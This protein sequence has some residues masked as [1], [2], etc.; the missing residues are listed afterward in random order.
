MFWRNKPGKNRIDEKSKQ[1]LNN[2]SQQDSREQEQAPAQAEETED[3]YQQESPSITREELLMQNEDAR[4]MFESIKS[5]RQ[6]VEAIKS[7]DSIAFSEEVELKNT[8]SKEPSVTIKESEEIIAA[9]QAILEKAREDEERER[10]RLAEMKQR[11]LKLREDRQKAIE[12]QRK[13]AKISEE[14]E[15]K[16][17][18]AL[19]AEKNAKEVARKK[20]LELM[21]AERRA[22]EEARLKKAAASAGGNKAESKA[23]SEKEQ[24]ASAEEMAAFFGSHFDSNAVHGERVEDLS[25]LKE[26]LLSEQEKQGEILNKISKAAEKHTE[27]IAQVQKAKV[28]E[29]AET[30]KK[31][32]KE[33]QQRLQRQQLKAEQEKARAEEIIRRKKAK[34]EAAEAE[35]KAKAAAAAE[36]RARAEAAM[37]EKKA[38]T[39]AA[40][41]AK[42]AKAEA[43]MAE[44][45]AKAEA[46]AEDKRARAQHRLEEREK[47]RAEKVY[48]AE[49]KERL[50]QE[51][52]RLAKERARLEAQKK[53]EAELGGGI[54]NV[55]GVQITTELNKRPEFSWKHFFGFISRKEKK[56]AKTEEEKRALEERKEE[57]KENAR[58]AAEILSRQRQYKYE[59][60]RIGKKMAVIKNY[61]E[62]HKKVLLMG[63]AAVIMLTVGTAGVFN[64]CTAYEYSYNGQTLGM[65]KAK[66]D[67]LKITDLVQ[68]AL[69]EEKDMDIVIDAKD[70]ITFKRVYALGGAKVDTSEE[71]LKRLTY[72]GDLN[73]KAYGIYVN[74][75]RAGVVQDKDTAA[76]VMQ[77]IKDRYA[78]V[79]EGSKIEE[80]VFIEK[81]D[82]REINTDLENLLS[83]EEMVNVLCTSGE[84][85]TLHKVVAG[86]TLNSIA[87]LYSMTEE[88]ILEDNENIDSKKLNVGSTIVIKQNAPI[89]TV[90]I[91]ELVTYDKVIE[92]EVEKQNDSNIYEGYT[93]TKQA[94]ED[95]LSEVTSRIVTVNGEQ[96][97][98]EN[99]VTTVKKEP[100]KEI[101]MVGTKERPPT[102]GSGKYIWPLKVDFRQTTGFESRWGE[103]HNA[104]D[105][106]CNAGSDIYA[107]DGGTVIQAGYMGSYGNV[108]FIDHQNGQ[109]TRYAHCSKL[110]VKKGDKVFQGQLIAK[111]GSTGRSTGPHLHFEVRI[112]GTPKNPLK[113]LP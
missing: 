45:R 23:F 95:G 67:V 57:R 9:K 76:K 28:E 34:A 18:E 87:K 97:E 81:V 108:I 37:A 61:C 103:F 21:E 113:Y 83:E 41:A 72:M 80:A 40:M 3:A 68:D 99:L 77:D 106:A 39:E 107:A 6:S 79:Q 46:V 104:I 7:D 91:T 38:R 69:T 27:K 13:A 16:R 58:A 111:V 5:L 56:A 50:K 14:A 17:I 29:V 24:K 74:G 98:E 86:D 55:Q 25:E 47:R 20:A 110:L 102:V 85:E 109:E 78:G 54:V 112:N 12:A 90:K 73:V 88:E 71:V 42:K 105:L 65:V 35:K 89:L 96:I 31:A 63:L 52:K 30:N 84:K 32:K 33:Q 22:K 101:V 62:E 93:E 51:K 82:V 94:G 70:D 48:R 15:R 53:A 19:E 60:S 92:H 43:V 59:N 8:A 44:K 75:K 26:T 1:Q 36:K 64:Y 11:E 66:D 4:K 100:V 49:E 10:R 2:Q